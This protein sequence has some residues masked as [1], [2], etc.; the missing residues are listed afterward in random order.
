MSPGRVDARMMLPIGLREQL[1]GAD[2]IAQDEIYRRD[3]VIFARLG[4]VMFASQ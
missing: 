2:R 1:V 3:L 4:S